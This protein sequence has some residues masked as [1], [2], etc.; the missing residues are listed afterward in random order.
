MELD[1]EKL[2][3]MVGMTEKQADAY[4]PEPFFVRVVVVDGKHLTVTRDFRRDRVNVE[5]KNGVI[6]KVRGIS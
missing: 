5:V 1:V 4:L 3:E 2:E 6:T